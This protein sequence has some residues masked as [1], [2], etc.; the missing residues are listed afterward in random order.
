[1]SHPAPLAKL[2]GIFLLVRHT[3]C[4]MS[5]VREAD[6]PDDIPCSLCP[7]LSQF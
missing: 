4:Y 7:V 5:Q 6:I 2:C 3:C 1:M